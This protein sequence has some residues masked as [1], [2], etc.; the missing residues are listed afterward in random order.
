MLQSLRIRNIAIVEDVAVEFGDGLNVI[1]GETG[2]GKSVLVGALNLVLGD[3]ADKS[4]LRAGAD[5][6]SVEAVFTVASPAVL[7]EL[8]LPAGDDG[9]LIIR[10]QITA[11]G[12]GK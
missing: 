1:T 3:R 6:C 4:L 10:R 7:D 2:A 9:A 8:G 5:Q 11:A 12:T